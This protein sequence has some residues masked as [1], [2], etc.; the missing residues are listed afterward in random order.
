[1]KT[2]QEAL[3]AIL[4]ILIGNIPKSKL[5]AVLEAQELGWYA[6]MNLG[7]SAQIEATQ[8][9]Q[10]ACLDAFDKGYNNKWLYD[11]INAALSGEEAQ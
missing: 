10:E 11:Y 2:N 9:M 5:E 1:M 4:H 7:L 6:G 3:A 8:K